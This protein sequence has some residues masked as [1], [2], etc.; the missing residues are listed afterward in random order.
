MPLAPLQGEERDEAAAAAPIVVAVVG[1]EAAEDVARKAEPR[2]DTS[3]RRNGTSCRLK[4]VTKSGKKETR[5]ENKEDQRE[6]V[7]WMD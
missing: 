5:K 6:L 2:L 7:T 4:N 3:L 1:G